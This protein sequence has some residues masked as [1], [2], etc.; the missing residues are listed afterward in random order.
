MSSIGDLR[1]LLLHLL[2]FLAAASDLQDLISKILGSQEQAS[3]VG[4][5][6]AS[7]ILNTCGVK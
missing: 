3:E 1:L 7:F 2:L 5:M 4:Q 6:V